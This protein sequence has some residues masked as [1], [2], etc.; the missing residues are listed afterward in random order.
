MTPG[1]ERKDVADFQEGS[2]LAQ[3][4]AGL[5]QMVDNGFS[6]GDLDESLLP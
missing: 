3:E 1:A 4:I 2:L 6:I 5:I